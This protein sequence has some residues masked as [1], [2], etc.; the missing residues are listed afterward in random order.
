MTKREFA[1]AAKLAKSDVDLPS[2][3]SIDFDPSQTH[4]SIESLA[5][6]IRGASR[7]LGGLWLEEEA[8]DVYKY[9]NHMIVY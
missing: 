8:N 7:T 6:L 2:Y 9:L 1:I 5:V 3:L 4:I